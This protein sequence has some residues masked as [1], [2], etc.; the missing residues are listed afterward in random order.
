MPKIATVREGNSNY[1]DLKSHDSSF[2]LEREVDVD[3][4]RGAVSSP[5]NGTSSNCPRAATS[6]TA[7]ATIRRP[8]CWSPS[9]DRRVLSYIWDTT[10]PAGIMESASSIPL[11]HIYRRRLPFRRGRPEPLAHRK[12]QPG[13]RLREGLR[14]SRAPREGN[15]AADQ[16][17][18]HRHFRREL[19]LR[20]GLPQ[21]PAIMILVTG[22][23]GFIGSH[24]VER[25]VAQGRAGALP[26]AALQRDRQPARVASNWRRAIWKAAPG[27]TQALRGV[28]TV[29]HL[30]GVTK[31]RTAA[32]YDRGNAV[33]HGQSAAAPRAMSSDLCT[34]AAWPRPVPVP[35]IGRSPKRTNRGP[36]RITAAR[37]WPASK[38]SGSRRWP[39][40]PSSSGRRW[41]TGRA[42]A[43]FSRCF[44]PSPAAGW[45]RSASAPRRFSHIYVGDLVDGLIARGRSATG[46]GGEVFYLARRH[47]SLLG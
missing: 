22:G 26:G 46:A 33:G 7:R 2:G 9:A 35:P 42:T 4:Q 15:P 12:P 45:R 27:S 3:P 8:R 30:A 24:L 38:P 25:L 36:S 44:A 34:S 20:S 10:A 47:A 21:H 28:D 40:G 29:I 1:L 6:G 17:A 39:P 16:H 32:D 18:A 23:T 11:V 19:L 31:A 37:S 13:R 43:T 5:G 41:S 14:P